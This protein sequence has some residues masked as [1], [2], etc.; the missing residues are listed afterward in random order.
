MRL[1]GW[2][3]SSIAIAMTGCAHPPEKDR[4]RQW[5]EDTSYT[6]SAPGAQGAID[7]GHDAWWESLGGDP[8]HQLVRMGLSRNLDIAI[9]LTRVAEAR[10]GATAQGS[11]LWPA[12][13][14]HGA[15]VNEQSGLPQPVKQ[16]RPDTR[17]WQA[18]LNLGWEVD[19]FG[20]NRMASDAA[21]QDV[22]R[23]DAGV[24]GARL[25]L[26]SEI[27]TQYVLRQG[28]MA[29][30][31]LMDQLIGAQSA[32]LRTVEHRASEGEASAIQ[33]AAAR[34][35]LAE[36]RAQRQPLL[37]LRDVTRARLLT[38]T[39]ATPQEVDRLL[40]AAP[41]EPLHAVPPPSVPP[42]Q[43]L[44]LLERRPDLMAARTAWLAEQKRLSVARTDMLP[45]F[46]L[47]LLT[48][49]QDLR[50]NGMDLSPA[51]FQETALV[52]ALPLF[53][54]GRVQAGIERQEAVLQRAA[55]QYE[56][57]ARRAVEDVESALS[58][59]KHARAR[60]ADMAHVTD[61]RQLAAHLGER[62]FDE[63]QIGAADRLALKLAQLAAQLNQTESTERAWLSRI[64][65]HR[66]MGGGWQTAPSHDLEVVS[67]E[68]RP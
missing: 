43:P 53:N 26:A 41:H 38:L 29:R 42:G 68:S 46:F 24:A 13:S 8:L 40:A 23:S 49:R 28:A 9:A 54:A 3:M 4:A 50:L 2:A 35:Q 6:A 17:V 36:L 59:F 48:G 65:L 15:Y 64:Q 66:A 27:A 22:L 34:A 51:S 67:Q 25:V 33:A 16:G 44:A 52:F 10:A 30:L 5:L 37:T 1:S 58:D 47:S 56:Q 14:M 12:L 62:L 60:A 21:T 63:G 19:V 39:V 7:A 20:R 18:A 31:Q 11:A 57:A 45:R 61:A 32:V 55:L